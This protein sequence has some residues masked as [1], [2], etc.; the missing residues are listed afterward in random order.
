MLTK[1]QKLVTRKLT[2][3]L[4]GRREGPNSKPKVFTT[5]FRTRDSK[6]IRSGSQSLAQEIGKRI[7]EKKKIR[8]PLVSHRDLTQSLPKLCLPDY[9]T[10]I[11]LE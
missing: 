11:N 10:Q 4:L 1:I 2:V 9:H 6:S 8:I 5:S 7:T 3:L